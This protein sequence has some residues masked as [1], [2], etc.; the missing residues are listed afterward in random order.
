MGLAVTLR[1]DAV[2]HQM[3][4]TRLLPGEKSPLEGE[5]CPTWPSPRGIAMITHCSSGGTKSEPLLSLVHSFEKP[6]VQ[7]EK[8]QYR[9]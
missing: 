7:R 1:R 8:E 5:E 6:E 4:L 2:H 9:N 3:L